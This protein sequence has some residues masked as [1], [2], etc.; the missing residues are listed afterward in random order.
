MG[1]KYTWFLGRWLLAGYR[2]LDAGYW[3]L[4]AGYQFYSKQLDFMIQVF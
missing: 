3:I 1:C 2:I 4:D